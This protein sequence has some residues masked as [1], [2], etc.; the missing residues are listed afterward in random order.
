[1]AD[2]EELARLL[3]SVIDWN[4]WRRT[5]WSVSV[6]LS[7]ADLR[8]PS[9]SG[10]DLHEADLRRARLTRA[11]LD[12]ANLTAANLK[13]ASAELVNLEGADLDG[14]HLVE[15]DLNNAN[16]KRAHFRNA[17]L[18]GA[19]LCSARLDGTNFVE[20]DLSGA[21]LSRAMLVEA[22]FANANLKDA[23]GL[24]ACDHRGPSVIDHRTLAKS[25]PL[26]EIFLR[27]CG[28]P[29]NLITYLPSLVSDGAI[30]FFSCFISYSH[31]DKSFA[32]RLHDTLQL[33]HLNTRSQ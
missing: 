23:V 4:S 29:E 10:A 28:L 7:G 9:L 31:E 1:M 27:G 2:E 30:Q 3:R 33:G 32:R 21:N 14:A 20:T 18:C 24:E 6:N 5:N 17:D 19:L 11:I 12:G 26:P 16:L 22:V 13:G 15:A 25:W 8:H